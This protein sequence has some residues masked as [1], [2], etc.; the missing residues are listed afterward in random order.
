M[1]TYSSSF[2]DAPLG[3]G[4]ESRCVCWIPGSL[5]SLAPRNDD[6]WSLKVNLVS[7]RIQSRL[8]AFLVL[9]AA[10]RAGH[11]DAA[12]QRA[13]GL[14]HQTTGEHRDAWHSCQS[15]IHLAVADHFCQL[16]GAAAKTQRGVGLVGRDLS[17][18]QA[19]IA[20]T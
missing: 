15:G 8:G 7:H 18:G 5:V 2:R 4:P 17:G 12:K 13:A 9:V 3:A 20:V 14:D 6:V 19:R 1:V 16:S 10:G 11:T